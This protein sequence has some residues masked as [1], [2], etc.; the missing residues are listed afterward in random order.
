MSGQRVPDWRQLEVA[1]T[2]A[3]G[4]GPGRC[5]YSALV[6]SY[7]PN[8]HPFA[9]GIQEL[10]VLWFKLLGILI[11]EG[12]ALFLSKLSETWNMVLTE[13]TKL[14]DF[15]SGLNNVTGLVSHI[16]VYLQALGWTPE[17]FNQWIDPEGNI[18]YIDVLDY[19]PC[20]LATLI[21]S[22]IDSFHNSPNL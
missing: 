11:Q 22:L 15:K 7:G 8:G 13:H 2:D 17:A 16:I 1:A 4:F 6:V 20:S 9:R 21:H 12:R 5:R 18:W 3:A 10:L 19:T 14:K